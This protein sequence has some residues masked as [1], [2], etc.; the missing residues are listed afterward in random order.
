MLL[1]F[2]SFYNRIIERDTAR[3][4]KRFEDAED[5]GIKV[6]VKSVPIEDIVSHISDIGTCIVLTNANLLSCETCNYF[7][8]CGAGDNIT[9]TSCF[10]LRSCGTGAYQG[11]YVLAIGFDK[12]KR[13]IYYRNPTLRDRVCVMSYDRFDEARNAYGTDEDLIFIAASEDED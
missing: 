2:Q 5:N 7:S 11:H 10:L 9:N 12:M 13:K 1:L 8:L 6:H 3:V 4:L